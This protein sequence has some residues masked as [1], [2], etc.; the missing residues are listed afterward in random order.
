MVT[1]RYFLS[2]LQKAFFRSQQKL[3]SPDGIP[4]DGGMGFHYRKLFHRQLAWLE[5]NAIRNTHF[6]DIM[7]RR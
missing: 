6:A 2:K 7:Q 4:P 5:Q 3:R 1:L